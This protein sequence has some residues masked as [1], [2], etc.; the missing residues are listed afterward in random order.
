[1]S[2]IITLQTK[3]NK[4]LYLTIHAQE[5]QIERSLLSINLQDALSRAITLNSQNIHKH[6]HLK[7][8]YFNKLQSYNQNHIQILVNPYYN[9]QFRVDTTNNNIVTLIK[10]KEQ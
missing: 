9:I 10:Y 4:T 6:P 2:N 5:R 7:Q 3:T 8:T 1:M